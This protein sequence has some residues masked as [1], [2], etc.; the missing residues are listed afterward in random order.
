M[1]VVAEFK[2]KEHSIW[3]KIH[4]ASRVKEVLSASLLWYELIAT[5]L[6]RAARSS[7]HDCLCN[8]ISLKHRA[9]KV[10]Q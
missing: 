6:T 3:L 5:C 2:N 10:K 8:G 4:I 9:Y 7:E 1:V